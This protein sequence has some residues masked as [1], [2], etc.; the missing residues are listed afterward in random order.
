MCCRTVRAACA[1][2]SARGVPLKWRDGQRRAFAGLTVLRSFMAMI[3][4][5]FPCPLI[6]LGLAF[7]YDGPAWRVR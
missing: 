7:S 5:P 4:L 3:D 1:G 6:A 2:G